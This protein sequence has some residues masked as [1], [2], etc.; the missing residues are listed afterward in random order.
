[1]VTLSRPAPRRSG[2]SLVEMVVVLLV[3]GVLASAV[4]LMLPGDADVLRREAERFAARVSAARDEA[5][6]GGAPVAV[7]VSEA[8]Y[9]FEKREA[10]AW[11]PAEGGGLSLAT[12]RE[13]TQVAVAVPGGRT[14]GRARVV[15]DT[16][17]LASSELR[18]R[19]ARGSATRALTIARDGM[20]RAD[21]GS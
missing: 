9:Y 19:L 17:G 15:F 20:V 4:V 13:G 16:V 5:I 7:V 6:A 1:M 18:L 21:A 11:A 2:F 10:G 12:W 14:G 3:M 8:G